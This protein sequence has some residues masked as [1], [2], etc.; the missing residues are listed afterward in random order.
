M[1]PVEAITEGIRVRVTSTWRPERSSPVAG[2]WFFT[3]TVRIANES[4]VTA[5]LRRRRWEIVNANGHRHEV[6]GR[7]VVGVEPRLAPGEHYEYTSACPL[8]TP[9]GSM[10]GTYSMQ[11]DDGTRFE[12][13]IP[14]F[15]LS[16]PHSIH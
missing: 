5:T 10:T 3:Y 13:E 16:A 8:D 2:R 1:A 14:R 11:T 4:R 15:V 9:F 7:G 12:A 6:E